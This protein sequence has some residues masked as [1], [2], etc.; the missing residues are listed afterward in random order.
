MG[1]SPPD[2]QSALWRHRDFLLLWRGQ[3]VSETGSQ[4]TLLALPLVAVVLL[5]ATAFQ[6]G[7]LSAAATGA[8]LLVS[9]PAEAAKK[10]EVRVTR[11]KK[12]HRI[13]TVIQ[14]AVVARSATA[15]EALER[16][17]IPAPALSR[18]S[19]LMSTGASLIISDQGLGSE[20]GTET[21]FI[22][23]TR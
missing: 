4:I 13:E 5:K 21:D 7:L 23:L 11:D 8:Y 9:L 19:S 15:A 18:I 22:V 10:A 16:V 17:D 2:R 3:T 6:V 14:P 12:G 20:T 1:S